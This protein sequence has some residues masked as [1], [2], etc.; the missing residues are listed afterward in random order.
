MVKEKR[1]IWLIGSTGLLGHALSKLLRGTEHSVIE[2]ARADVD[3]SDE[4]A[5]NLFVKSEK[6]GIILNAAGYT[7]VD[8]AELEVEL[9]NAINAIG[10]G[11]VARAGHKVG[12]RTVYVST[13]YVFSG[14][15]ETPHDEEHE[16]NPLN[17][18]AKSKLQGEEA[19]LATIKLGGAAYVVRTSW[20]FGEFGQNFVRTV[21]RLM[22]EQE[23][24]QIV[25][26]QIS[27]PTSVSDL[28]NAIVHLVGLNDG[29]SAPTGIYH[30]ANRGATSW[31]D[32]ALRIRHACVAHRI[33]LAVQRITPITSEELA[34]P[35]IR[36]KFSV[37][38]TTKITE[39]QIFPRDWEDALDE[40]I[41]AEINNKNF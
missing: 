18:Y 15:D 7:R 11:N 10:A 12:A 2:T 9:A 29:R 36:P 23:E 39:F 22:K 26:D 25:N 27:S 3:I 35:A 1:P 19:T 41:R 16:T 20:L 28:A 6:P 32:F 33:P 4:R 40:Y 31:Y 30:F 17:A 24:L 37:L 34:R 14:V 21:V 38:D 13:D 8:D 5:V